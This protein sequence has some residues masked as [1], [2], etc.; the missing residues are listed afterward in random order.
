MRCNTV[1]LLR[2]RTTENFFPITV[3]VLIYAQAFIRIITLHGEG[4]GR[5]L[6]ARVLT[7]YT[8]ITKILPFVV[9][10]CHFD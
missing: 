4:N 8:R 3:K 2:F 10:D 9:Y 7:N 1:K 6:E 5:L